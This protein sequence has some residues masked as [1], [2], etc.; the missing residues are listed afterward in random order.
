VWF[1]SVPEKRF[2]VTETATALRTVS[3]FFDSGR[4]VYQVR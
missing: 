1:S 2:N 4:V 3:R